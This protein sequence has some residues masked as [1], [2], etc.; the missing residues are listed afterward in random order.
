MFA[1]GL[2]LQSESDLLTIIHSGSHQT[3]T[4]LHWSQN[5]RSVCNSTTTERA[6]PIIITYL[7]LGL[8]LDAW[9]QS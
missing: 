4:E 2:L 8:L 1:F 5:D 3:L 7:G 6:H 9:R